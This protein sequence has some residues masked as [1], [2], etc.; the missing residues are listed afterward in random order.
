MSDQLTDIRT[1]LANVVSKV[2]RRPTRVR[3]PLKNSGRTLRG[4]WLIPPVIALLVAALSPSLFGIGDQRNIV[5]VVVYL[6]MVSGL[7]LSFGYGGELAFGQIAMFAAGAYTTGILFNHGHSDLL[8]SILLAVLIAG[9]LGFVTGV[10]GLRL[11]SW[12]LALISLFLVLVLPSLLDLFKTQTGGVLGLGGISNGSVFGTVLGWRAFFWFSIAVGMVW[13]ICMRNLIMSRYGAALSVL[14]ESPV[15]AA[16]LGLSSSRLRISAYILGGMPAGA[17]GVIYAELTGYLSSSGFVLS[18]FITVLAAS[19]VG[20]SNSI[21]G[22][23]IGAA[24]LV[25]GPL[26]TSTAAQYSLIAYGCFLIAVG[27]LARGGLAGLARRILPRL[28]S[29]LPAAFLSRVATVP[30]GDAAPLQIDGRRLV[31]T[32]VG[33]SFG[34]FR[35]LA[36]VSLVAE[37]GQITAILGANGAGKTT[38]LNTVSGFVA[39]DQGEILVGEQRSD[40]LPGHRAARLGIGRTF[41]T[42]SI[43]ADMTVLEVVESG[44]LTSGNLGLL[45][46]IFR[47]P[48]FRRTRREDTQLAMAALDFG[49][50]AHL[51]LLP[52]RS[53]PLGT[54]RLLEVVRAV[55]GEP[56]V[57]LLDEP[58]AGLDDAGLRELATL[59]RR[60][61]DA[62]AA[63]VLVEHNV[64][65]VLGLADVIHVMELGRVIASGTPEEI[66]DNPDVIASY[67]G[68][69]SHEARPTEVRPD[70]RAR[71]LQPVTGPTAPSTQAGQR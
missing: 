3:K 60:S 17:A 5:L 57:M 70:S 62:G 28:L 43:P 34:G 33:K 39:P 41:Q 29:I 71:P 35:A 51:A 47:S 26:Q 8:L 52:A 23:V 53:L 64:P 9:V 45:G 37:P 55:A 30:S 59:V 1:T 15:L 40:G 7:N 61:R 54:R 49:G 22:A 27:I 68:R 58:A 50:L 63:V 19:V 6:L 25:L 4:G 2:A 13:I 42:P 36:G 46:S 56:Q 16:S 10:P 18:V 69:R 48:K 12:T 66:K 21:Y 32:D 14:K 11:S 38:L 20:G 31:V 24:I 44:R 67:L 65:F